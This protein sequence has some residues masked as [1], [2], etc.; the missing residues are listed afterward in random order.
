LIGDAGKSDW[1]RCVPLFKDY[2]P[3]VVNAFDFPLQKDLG[4]L[5]AVEVKSTPFHCGSSS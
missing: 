2:Y 1:L 5:A 4:N 3:G